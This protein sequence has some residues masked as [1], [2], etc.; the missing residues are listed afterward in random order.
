MRDTN[1]TSNTN[2]VSDASDTCGNE[3][4]YLRW[5]DTE[6]DPCPERDGF[7]YC[8]CRRVEHDRRA[9]RVY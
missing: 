5:F 9:P 4:L 6:D 3:S 8:N 7:G 1:S 2:D